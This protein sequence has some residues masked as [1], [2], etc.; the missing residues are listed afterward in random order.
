MSQ[1]PRK[2]EVGTVVGTEVGT[3][4]ALGG[5]WVG[6]VSSWGVSF[7]KSVAYTQPLWIRALACIS[8]FK[9]MALSAGSSSMQVNT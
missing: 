4:W 2:Y 8:G 5:H 9:D 7:G 6:T 3:G 1:F